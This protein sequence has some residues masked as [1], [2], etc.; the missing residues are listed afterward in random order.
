MK[1][2]YILKSIYPL[3]L[4]NHYQSKTKKNTNMYSNLPKIRAPIPALTFK[5]N[6]YPFLW[7]QT[8]DQPKQ[9]AFNWQI[10]ASDPSSN[11]ISAFHSKIP[12]NRIHHQTDPRHNNIANWLLWFVILNVLLLSFFSF[13][14]LLFLQPPVQ[15]DFNFALGIGIFL[16][17]IEYKKK[18]VKWSTQRAYTCT[19][20][21]IAY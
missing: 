3:E 11:I 6:I 10:G 21:P 16:I 9:N 8:P 7:F 15:L 13:S 1:L 5:E 19:H 20:S 18:K 12:H 14:L 4:H 17:E 2:T